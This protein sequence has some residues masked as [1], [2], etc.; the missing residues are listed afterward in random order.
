MRLNHIES[1]LNEE[2]KPMFF[3]TNK[4]YST[5]HTQRNPIAA[6]RIEAWNKKTIIFIDK[7]EY[8]SKTFL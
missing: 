8:Y 2:K 3:M 1:F 5:E 6:Y 7:F 4:R